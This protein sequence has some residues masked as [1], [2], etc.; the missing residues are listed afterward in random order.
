MLIPSIKEISGTVKHGSQ[1]KVLLKVEVLENGAS[2]DKTL[3][4][5]FKA[6]TRRYIYPDI[7]GW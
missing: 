7:R 1:Y 3:E 4:F 6:N 2:S 5:N